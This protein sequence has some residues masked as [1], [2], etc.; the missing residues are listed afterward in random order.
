MAKNMGEKGKEEMRRKRKS[1][2]VGPKNEYLDRL[3]LGGHEL[4]TRPERGKSVGQD[5]TC[6]GIEGD[7]KSWP[8]KCVVAQTP[9]EL[10]RLSRKL[11]SIR[12]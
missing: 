9:R 5:P 2:W 8:L 12:K 7:P 4:V 11:V 6:S 10:E 3:R 1:L